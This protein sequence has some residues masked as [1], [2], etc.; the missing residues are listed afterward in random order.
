MSIIYLK[1]N[2]D[3]PSPEQ[4]SLYNKYLDQALVWANTIFR[5][6]VLRPLKEGESLEETIRKLTPKEIKIKENDLDECSD[7]INEL[8]TTVLHRLEEKKN[9]P[10]VS[11]LFE[12]LQEVQSQLDQAI[13][14][15]DLQYEKDPKKLN[16]KDLA[17]KKQALSRKFE[18]VLEAQTLL[19]TDDEKISLDVLKT[20][21]KDI[22]DQLRHP[23]VVKVQYIE[24]KDG[25]VVEENGEPLQEDLLISK[26]ISQKEFKKKDKKGNDILDKSGNPIMISFEEKTGKNL[27]EWSEIARAK[28]RG[29]TI[30]EDPRGEQ[31]IQEVPSSTIPSGKFISTPSR[32][33]SPKNDQFAM[34]MLLQAIQHF[35]PERFPGVPFSAFLQKVMKNEAATLGNMFARHHRL[36]GR[37]FESIHD[38]VPGA[39]EGDSRSLEE[40]LQAEEP[41]ISILEENKDKV[42]EK[43]EKLVPRPPAKGQPEYGNLLWKIFEDRFITGKDLAEIAN[44]LGFVTADTAAEAAILKDEGIIIPGYEGIPLE[45]LLHVPEYTQVLWKLFNDKIDKE[46]AD[47]NVSEEE[48]DNLK[49]KK[50]EF[51]EKRKGSKQP[52]TNRVREYITGPIK[53]VIYSIPDLKDWAD[54]YS[55]EFEEKSKESALET[56][57]ESISKL[58]KDEINYN[59]LRNKIQQKL[60]SINA[61]LFT[62]YSH[63]YEEGLTNPE[64]AKTMK[65]SPPRIT[66]LK[67]RVVAALVSLPEIREVIGTNGSSSISSLRRHLYWEGDRVKLNSINKIGTI[68]GERAEDIFDINLDNGNKVITFKDDLE[69]YSTLEESVHNLISHYFGETVIA[70]QCYLSLITSSD[71]LKLVVVDLKPSSERIVTA[72]LYINDTMVDL[73]NI[74]VDN[75]NNLVAILKGHLG[76]IVDI[77]P[78]FTSLFH[79]TK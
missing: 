78:P 71:G 9:D 3:G 54:S 27:E 17:A 56:F 60:T 19:L 42:K 46:L 14:N 26:P 40:V 43:L 38:V 64:T 74:T 79:E 2:G 63:L 57:L 11:K 39:G 65:L 22:D 37:T 32:T 6:A 47:P 61:Q 48:K 50:T 73:T 31:E 45:K 51:E 24:D 44:E 5:E 25:N 58:Q 20:L 36:H 55:E 52:M 10:Q 33:T 72:R 41:P 69:H 18:I 62:V 76:D 30:H 49:K 66:G 34:D 70:H 68:V 4:I 7:R 1:S 59:L 29:F 67:K 16:P 23:N 15:L 8:K 53:E 28:A 75:H 21:Y 77:D 13:K 35:D 12:E